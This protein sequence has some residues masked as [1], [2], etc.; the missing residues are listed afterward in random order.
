MV[1]WRGILISHVTEH[2]VQYPLRLFGAISPTCR[3]GLA[4][5]RTFSM[6]SK[7][8]LLVTVN[9]LPTLLGDE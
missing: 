1:S 5:Q 7:L 6:D 3:I 2:S 4:A 8:E 9:E